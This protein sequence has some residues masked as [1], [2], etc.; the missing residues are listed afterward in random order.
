MVRK[1]IFH[2]LVVVALYHNPLSAEEFGRLFTTPAQ[3]QQL[4]ELRKS[5]ADIKVE[6]LSEEL[7][8]EQDQVTESAGTGELVLRGLVYR[9]DGKNTAWV[10]DSNSYEGDLSAQYARVLEERVAAGQVVIE[11]GGADGGQLSLKVGQSFNPGDG[12]IRDLATDDK[13]S[14]HQVNK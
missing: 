3:R 1:L 13:K 12:T 4:D 8:I 11:I 5:Q 2:C 6:V 14:A 10:N 7:T 9:S